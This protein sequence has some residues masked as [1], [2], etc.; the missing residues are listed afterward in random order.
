MQNHYHLYAKKCISGG[1]QGV[2]LSARPKSENNV[3]PFNI[4]Y[5]IHPEGEFI[6]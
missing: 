6:G 3:D 5:L 1:I 2:L 4:V